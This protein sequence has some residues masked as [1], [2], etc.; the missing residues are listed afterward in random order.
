MCQEY[1]LEILVQNCAKIN[2]LTLKY[3]FCWL[4]VYIV[5]V[6]IVSVGFVGYFLFIGDFIRCYS[7]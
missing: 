4:P 1:S 7:Y 5:V 2:I 3:R 6:Y